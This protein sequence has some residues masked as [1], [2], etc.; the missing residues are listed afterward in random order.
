MSKLV[1]L[2]KHHSMHIQSGKQYLDCLLLLLSITHKGES[3]M[4]VF[5]YV[6]NSNI[7][8]DL[9]E[10]SNVNIFYYTLFLCGEIHCCSC[11]DLNPPQSLSHCLVVGNGT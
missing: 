2:P 10:I 7:S 5:M 8:P 11:I 3:C 9:E 1:S 4:S 6:C